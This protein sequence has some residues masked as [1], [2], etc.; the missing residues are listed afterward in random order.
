LAPDRERARV[1]VPHDPSPDV[2]DD[3]DADPQPYA[4]VLRAERPGRQE[5]DRRV[6]SWCG[7]PRRQRDDM[8]SRLRAGREPEPPRA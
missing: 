1:E 3:D 2:E 5:R 4:H 8:E 7:P 6:I